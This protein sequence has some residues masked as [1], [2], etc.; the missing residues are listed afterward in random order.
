ML[1][2][3]QACDR[4]NPFLSIYSNIASQK[5]AA[6]FTEVIPK[7]IVVLRGTQRDRQSYPG[8]CVQNGVNLSIR[9]GTSIFLVT[10]LNF[11]CQVGC[12]GVPVESL[13]N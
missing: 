2:K 4:C 9:Y 12:R 10:S 5:P 1:V 8:T 13:S 6:T 7:C 11:P 3:V